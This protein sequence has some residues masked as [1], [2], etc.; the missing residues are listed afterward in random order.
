MIANRLRYLAAHH[1][2]QAQRLVDPLPPAQL[3]DILQDLADQAERLEA[4]AT[5][6]IP[7]AGGNG[8]VIHLL[9]PIATPG[10]PGAA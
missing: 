7:V 8:T 1:A 3:A 5:T 10:A 2:R 9:R 4:R 6:R